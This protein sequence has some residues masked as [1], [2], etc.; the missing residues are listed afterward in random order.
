MILEGTRIWLRRGYPE[1]THKCACKRVKFIV[2][3]GPWL[4]LC[5]LDFDVFWPRGQSK[6]K[7][8]WMHDQGRRRRSSFLFHMPGR[9]GNIPTPAAINWNGLFNMRRCLL[10][11]LLLKFG[12]FLI[13]YPCSNSNARTRPR[14]K[15]FGDPWET[16][17]RCMRMRVP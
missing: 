7:N 14:S 1:V 6:W 10:L 12:C 16:C 15:A 5:F 2:V 8:C 3:V 13:M 11:L 17:M 4:P 9:L